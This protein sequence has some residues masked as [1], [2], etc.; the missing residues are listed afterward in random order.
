MV[1]VASSQVAAVA[2]VDGTAVSPDR[3]DGVELVR[4]VRRRVSRGELSPQQALRAVPAADVARALV[5][6]VD[7]SQ[8]VRIARG[9]GVSPGV[10]SGV[11]VFSATEAVAAAEA[12]QAAVLFLPE[13]RPDDLPGMQAAV[14]TVTERGGLT[15]HAAVISRSLGHPCA[16][17]LADAVVDRYGRCLRTAAGEVVGHGTVVTVDGLA[18]TV[19]RG[20]PPAATR[21]PGIDAAVGW[22]LAQA[23][24]MP[25]LPVRVN[26]DTPTD[27]ARG[28]DAG[29]AGIGLCRVEHML[30]GERQAVLR[31][32]LLVDRGAS[33]IDALAE[34]Q[35]VLRAGFTA[36]LSVMDG[37]PVTVRL[38]DAPRHE[39]LPDARDG[40]RAPLP[41]EL[42]DQAQRL[43]EQN[44]MLGVR[45]VRAA[46]LMPELA[47]AQLEAL[48]D[49]TLELRLRGN[50]PRPEVLVPMVSA[51]EE[52]AW[53]RA[54]LEEVCRWRGHRPAPDGLRIPVGAMIET[55]R[56]ALLARALAVRADFLSIG[57]NDLSALVWGL[58]RDDA[59]LELLP[60]YVE[61]GILRESP[62]DAFD[63]TGVGELVRYTVDT[64]RVAKPE[65]PIGLCGEH[66][67]NPPD[68]EW[69][70]QAGLTYL[71]CSP[72]RVPITTY[73]AARHA[74]TSPE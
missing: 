69:F 68:V 60:S 56:A 58:S 45:G 4:S 41:A 63:T 29:A 66:A 3:L 49:A 40:A 11:A 13:T 54:L 33:A 15:S 38:L 36:I 62:F 46:L 19:Y 16:T 52:L 43:H 26:A 37:L 28:R 34:L 22:L 5:P 48:V 18:G 64:A 72:P 17:A 10:A 65:L 30:L 74:V 44:P 39:F 73:A 61:L 42:L 9:L 14:A 23:N 50:D 12:G 57:T 20:A 25:H 53:V 1:S 21:N 47:V 2:G 8:L 71:S 55:P 59:E 7:T 27:A 51:P 32:A 67:G 6:P 24:G 35:S 31:D 70:V